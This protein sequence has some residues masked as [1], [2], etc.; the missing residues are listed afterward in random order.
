MFAEAISFITNNFKYLDQQ[1]LSESNHTVN[2]LSKFSF[3]I[4]T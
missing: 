4:V 2:G 3:N 1:Q